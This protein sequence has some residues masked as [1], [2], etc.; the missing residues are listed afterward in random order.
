MRETGINILEHGNDY[1]SRINQP[2][3]PRKTRDKDGVWTLEERFYIHADNVENEIPS[4]GARNEN[5]PINN[6]EI[7]GGIAGY[8]NIREV[9]LTWKEDGGDWNGATN[10][11]D[12]TIRTHTQFAERD[13]EEHP[14]W[15]SLTSDDD[16]EMLKYYRPKFGIG[17]IIYV[18]TES[19]K[20]ANYT[21]K[22]TEILGDMYQVKA[23]PYLKDATPENWKCVGREITWTKKQYVEITDTWQYDY[24]EWEGSISPFMSQ[25]QLDKLIQTLRPLWQKKKQGK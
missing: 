7:N 12:I 13:I 23:P 18:V 5:L 20:K 6:V 24:Y 15:K 9:V 25:K 10:N 3:Y 8:P 4:V 11:K 22:Q 16:K 14:L 2:G 17:T 21:W 1:H 19:R